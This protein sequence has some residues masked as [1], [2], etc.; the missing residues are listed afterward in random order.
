MRNERNDEK[1]RNKNQ[2]LANAGQWQGRQAPRGGKIGEGWQRCQ[3]RRDALSNQ[4]P[5]H[6]K[7]SKAKHKH[8]YLPWLSNAA[9][10]SSGWVWKE[11]MCGMAGG[12]WRRACVCAARLIYASPVSHDEKAAAAADKKGDVLFGMSHMTC[13]KEEQREASKLDAQRLCLSP[14]MLT[15]CLLESA[16]QMRA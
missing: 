12:V 6:A 7:P 2:M 11:W 5:S 10:E 13:D 15:Q 1:T 8:T 3:P 14:L 4:P 9:E 16:N